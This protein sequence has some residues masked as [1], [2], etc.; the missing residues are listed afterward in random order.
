MIH[1]IVIHLMA[2]LRLHEPPLQ[3]NIWESAPRTCRS[4]TFPLRLHPLTLLRGDT[5]TRALTFSL[6]AEVQTQILLI[7]TVKKKKKKS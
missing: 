5:R 2:S 4:R 6:T 1:L 7:G 3:V